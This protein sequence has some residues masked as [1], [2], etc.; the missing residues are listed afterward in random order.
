MKRL[1]E[2]RRVEI[3]PYGLTRGVGLTPHSYSTWIGSLRPPRMTR[4]ILMLFY[5]CDYIEVNFPERPR[6]WKARL[7]YMPAFSPSK[8]L[9][10][11]LS[12]AWKT[13]SV[14]QGFRLT[15]WEGERHAY[16]P[17]IAE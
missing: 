10:W 17:E 11:R 1:Q 8:L 13:K 15:G 12:E 5:P 9:W 2:S 6:P 14:S 7:V 3:S 16:S 4:I